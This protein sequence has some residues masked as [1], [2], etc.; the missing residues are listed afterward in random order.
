M[1]QKSSKVLLILIKV[2]QVLLTIGTLV[3]TMLANKK[4][5]VGRH[6]VYEKNL[7]LETIHNIGT[8]PLTRNL[9]I[10]L[11][12]FLI[13][14]LIYSLIKKKPK[15]QV[16]EIVLTGLII[17]L[18]MLALNGILFI[19]LKAYL[20]IVMALAIL[21]IAQGLSLLVIVIRN[22]FIKKTPIQQSVE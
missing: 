9:F 2:F 13:L 8:A 16:F 4:V 6:V 3:L 10:G 12:I 18:L 11:V 7:F 15:T 5:G 17:T 1:F 19:T 22:S 20:Y 21:A 14:L